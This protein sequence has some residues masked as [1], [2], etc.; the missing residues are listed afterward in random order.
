MRQLSLGFAMVATLMAANAW[1]D[2][3][4]R[5]ES[6]VAGGGRVWTTMPNGVVGVDP[7][8][9]R[10]RSTIA[11]SSYGRVIGADAAT[12]WVVKPRSL[13]AADPARRRVRIRV[14]LHHDTY[15]GALGNGAVWLPSFTADTLTKI[16]AR[17]GVRRWDTRVPHSPQAVTVALGSVWVASIGRWHKGPGDVMVPDGPGIVSRLD[18]ANGTVRARIHVGKGPGAATA[19]NGALWVL[20]NRGVGASDTLDRIDVRTN[21]LV[22]SIRVPHWSSDVACG[23]RYC[24]VVSE[25]KSAGGVV[26]RIDPRTNRA[27]TRA[28]PRSWVPAA[29]VAVRGRVW[30]ADPGVAELI[31]IDARTL[32]VTKRVKIP[33]G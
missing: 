16:D 9:G 20:N 8:T 18:P 32:C 22:A 28:I 33:V 25:P 21:R 10:M 31:R 3:G 7:I 24:W 15:A 2:G 30:V 6:M 4:G 26:T 12:V 29:V 13:V 27:V 14:L 11:T 5:A 1:A 17:T 19:G 23:S